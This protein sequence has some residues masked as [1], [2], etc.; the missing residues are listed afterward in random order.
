MLFAD[1]NLR[2]HLLQFIFGG[3]FILLARL[4][5]AGLHGVYA[6][7]FVAINRSCKCRFSLVIELNQRDKSV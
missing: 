3:I 6:H 7:V 1:E 2:R 5:V 4:I